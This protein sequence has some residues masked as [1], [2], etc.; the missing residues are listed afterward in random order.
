MHLDLVTMSAADITVAAVLAGVLLLTWGRAGWSLEE[1]P[2]FVGAWGV[3]VLVFSIGGAV[4]L[5]SAVAGST[6]GVTL[7]AALTILSGAMKWNAA[8]RFAGRDLAPFWIAFGPVC[9]VL[10]SFAGLASTL[11]DRFVAACTLLAAYFF[12]AGLELR[13]TPDAGQSWPAIALLFL[14]GA[15][16]LYWIPIA[17]TEPLGSVPAALSSDWLPFV[18]LATLLQGVALAFVVLSMAKEREEAEQRYCALTD[19]L[20]GLPNRRALFEVAETVVERRAHGG[21]TPV[22]LLLFDLDCFKETNDTFGHTVG[23]EVLRLFAKIATRCL[24]VNQIVGRLGGEEFAAILPGI[25]GE[26]AM[27]EAER[28]REDFACAAGFV[29]GLPVGA[30]VSVGVAAD[31]EVDAGLSSLFRRADAALY[32]A[33]SGGRNQVVFSGEK[34][35]SP[36]LEPRSTVR[37]APTRLDEPQASLMRRKRAPAA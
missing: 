3:A 29:N 30:T 24:A 37:T 14:G 26:V 7:G 34:C 27:A 8:R 36:L 4:M 31:S 33:K 23:D 6:G 11:D 18:V 15:S 17:L 28:L 32:A 20:T 21:G 25:D 19:S 16:Y 12:A 35:R 1:A 10:V 2:R 22:S 5:G 9:F 13:R